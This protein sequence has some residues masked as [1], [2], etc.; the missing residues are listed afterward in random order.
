[1]KIGIDAKWFFNGPPS[2][3]VVVYNLIKSLVVQNKEHEIY[4]FL[5]RRTKQLKFPFVNKKLH[6]VYL[7]ADNNLLSNFFIVPLLGLKLKIDIF[8]GQN[9]SPFVSTFK[10][11]CF[12][13]DISFESNPSFFT[14]QELLYFFPM[15]IL[16]RRAHKV[17][18]ISISE[19][20]R[21]IKYSYNKP[22]NIY[23]VPNGID[24]NKFK[25]LCFHSEELIRATR[26]RYKLPEKYLLYLGRLN[27]RK[28]IDILLQSIS[29]LKNK[30]IPLVLAGKYDWKMYDV[31]ELINRYNLAHRTILTGYVEDEF[32]PSLYSLSKIFCFISYDEGFGLPPLEAMAS[33]VPVVVSD[34]D[35]H[36][37]VCG[38]AGFYVDPHKPRDVASKI[39]NL[40]DDESLYN[41][42][43]ELG[44]KRASLYSWEK[45]AKKLLECVLSLKSSS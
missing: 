31:N 17:S 36:R 13:H 39:D 11:I 7:W 10:R 15:K 26:E 42:K 8:I 33:G 5:D 12:I 18:T 14:K 25:P 1:M 40:L 45:S 32:L 37:E 19:K 34:I 41:Q 9:F 21:L 27:I 30:S 35:P 29:I 16:A 3:R 28:N 4:I 22:E 6:L 23:I 20:Q 24:H 2:G 38:Q 44:I 43:R